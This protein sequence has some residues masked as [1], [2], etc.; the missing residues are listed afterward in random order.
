LPSVVVWRSAKTFFA[1]CQARHTAKIFFCTQNFYVPSYSTCNYMFNI[2][3]FFRFFCY[4][5]LIC[6]IELNFFRK[7][8][9]KLQ[10]HGIMEFSDLKNDISVDECISRPYLGIDPKF[11][12]SC[13]GNTTTNEVRKSRNLSR[14][15]L[16]TCGG[17]DKIL[18]RFRGR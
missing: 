7:S 8:K 5:K 16:I 3:T 18:R 11:R 15:H 1:E 9:F 6:F 10:V 4:F 17:C 13:L 12:M 2:G 14:C